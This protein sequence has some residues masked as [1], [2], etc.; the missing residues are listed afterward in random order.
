M[1]AMPGRIASRE[2]FRLP[3][4]A[5]AP[6]GATC[7]G[8]HYYPEWESRICTIGLHPEDRSE[9]PNAE[10]LTGTTDEPCRRAMTQRQ[11]SA[12]RAR[13][14]RNAERGTLNAELSDG[15]MAS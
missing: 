14:E 11:A 2:K 5:E 10:K 4:R 3:V 6:E 1:T 12:R 15:R 9:G 7:V 13:R 8:F